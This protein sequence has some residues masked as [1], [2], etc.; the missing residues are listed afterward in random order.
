[1]TAKALVLDAIQK[2]PEESSFADIRERIEFMAAIREGLDAI[3]R[4]EVIPLA[5]VEKQI[6]EWA[7]R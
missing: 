4:G 3:A 6:D 5:D 7:S 1:M 2:L